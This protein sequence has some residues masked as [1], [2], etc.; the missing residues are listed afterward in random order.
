MDDKTFEYM[1]QRVDKARGKRKRK[2][3][4]IG[5]QEVY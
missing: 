2:G 3:V 5:E 1:A 4:G